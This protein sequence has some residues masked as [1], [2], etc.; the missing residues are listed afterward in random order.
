MNTPT[1]TPR[2]VVYHDQP[3]NS[4]SNTEMITP[5]EFEYRDQGPPFNNT[6]FKKY[7]LNTSKPIGPNTPYIDVVKR[8]CMSNEYTYLGSYSLLFEQCPISHSIPIRSA[9]ALTRNDRIG[10]PDKFIGAIGFVGA[11]GVVLALLYHLFLRSTTSNKDTGNEDVGN[12]DA[13]NSLQATAVATAA[14]ATAD[15]ATDDNATDRPPPLEPVSTSALG[16]ETPLTESTLSSATTLG[17]PTSPKEAEPV[18]I[19][20]NMESS[21]VVK[22]NGTELVE[23]NLPEGKNIEIVKTASF[24]K[25]CLQFESIDFERFYNRAYDDLRSLRSE[26]V[27]QKSALYQFLA[28][29]LNF[30]DTFGAPGTRCAYKDNA[31]TLLKKK[32]NMPNSTDERN[33]TNETKGIFFMF[34]EGEDGED[35]YNF[36]ITDPTQLTSLYVKLK[37]QPNALDN[38]LDYFDTNKIID[39]INAF[40]S[41]YTKFKIIDDSDSNVFRMSNGIEVANPQKD[42]LIRAYMASENPDAAAATVNGGGRRRRIRRTTVSRKQKRRKFTNK[43]KR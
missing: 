13:G 35:F 17:S 33:G 24:G 12:K 5:R 8:M 21:F 27:M 28:P 22:R 34:A 11:L 20:I 42:A 18:V 2:K 29:K 19:Y 31:T 26:E 15:I 4:S 39:I 25:K 14:V 16:L 37:Q 41:H 9:S 23:L 10:T 40:P 43:Q 38:A 3:F 1:F 6:R 7:P 32:Y 36:N 30:V